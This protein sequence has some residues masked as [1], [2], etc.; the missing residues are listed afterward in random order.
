MGE[1]T[2]KARLLRVKIAK[3][4]HLRSKVTQNNISSDIIIELHLRAVRL[5]RRYNAIGTFVRAFT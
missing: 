5:P 3:R 4:G 1:E 2:G